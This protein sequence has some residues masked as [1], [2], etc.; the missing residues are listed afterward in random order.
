MRFRISILL[1]IVGYPFMAIYSQASYYDAKVALSQKKFDQALQLFD[2]TLERNPNHGN[3][4]F[5]KGYIYEKLKKFD[6]ANDLYISAVMMRMDDEL[7]DKAFWKIVLHLDSI[8]DWENL[9]IYSQKF[10]EF[11]EYNN[12]LKLYEKATLNESL[13]QPRVIETLSSVKKFLQAEDYSAAIKLL[14]VNLQDF[15]DAHYLRWQLTKLYLNESKYSEAIPHLKKLSK[16]IPGQWEYSYKLAICYYQTKA[17]KNSVVAIKKSKQVNKKPTKNFLFFANTLEGKNY[18][19]L[20]RYKDVVKLL[21]NTDYD[22]KKSFSHRVDLG[23]AYYFLKKY[24]LSKKRIQPLLA[25]T[26]KIKSLKLDLQLRTYLLGYRLARN[27]NQSAKTL[28]AAK[29]LATWI[30]DSEKQSSFTMSL[31][32][33]RDL[34]DYYSALLYA[35]TNF[36]QQKNWSFSYRLLKSIVIEKMAKPEQRLYRLEYAK[37]IFRD[38]GDAT[39][40]LDLLS[41]AGNTLDV[42]YYRALCYAQLKMTALTIKSLRRIEAEKNTWW[43]KANQESV[44]QVLKKDDENY[45]NYMLELSKES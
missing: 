35:G 27:D 15:P 31:T 36:N 1:L 45:R 40:S 13:K 24:A 37:A 28:A 34:E 39:K 26:K 32:H 4:V 10:L 5:Y 7:K 6:K 14:E 3:A 25:D 20:R 43:T 23:E 2:K 38:Q 30:H 18:L 9:K 42:Y 29:A 19:A 17:Y 16:E 12:V 8:G 11:R 21:E 44:F 41:K 22:Q 33:P